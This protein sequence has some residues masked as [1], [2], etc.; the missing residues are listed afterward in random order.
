MA[1]RN[2]RIT[3]TF[4][5]VGLALAG[6]GPRTMD[7]K[8]LESQIAAQLAKDHAVVDAV[9]CPPSI[10][11]KAGVSFECEVVLGGKSYAWVVAI[12]SIDKSG[13]DLDM[14]WKRGEAVLA[15]RVAE[16]MTE[17][18]GTLVGAPAAV[19]CG[20]PIRFLESDRTVRCDLAVGKVK[21]QLV[22]TLATD[23][24]LKAWRL[25]PPMLAKHKLETG[26]A[27]AIGDKL[28]GTATVDCG[29]EPLFPRPASGI[30]AC[31]VDTGKKTVPIGVEVELDKDGELT[32]KR[33]QVIG[34]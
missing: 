12:H 32:A 25:D 3:R 6:C 2:R 16:M 21:A 13:L 4:L 20:E 34:G 23:L 10:P 27:S 33:W 28:G 17:R 30:V 8:D 11:G 24:T 1:Q 31:S 15:S 9:H 26:L 14:H 7:T 19:D 5:A 29:S 22:M 18:V